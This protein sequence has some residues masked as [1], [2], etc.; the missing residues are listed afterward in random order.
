MA[1]ARTDT[2]PWWRDPDLGVRWRLALIPAHARRAAG[3]RLPRRPNRMAPR[4]THLLP[5]GQPAR[6]ATA[7]AGFVS[8]SPAPSKEER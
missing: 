7:I 3:R 5:R 4:R 8:Q 2:R 1:A 6:L